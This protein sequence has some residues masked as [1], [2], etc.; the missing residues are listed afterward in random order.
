MFWSGQRN[1]GRS[2]GGGQHHVLRSTDDGSLPLQEIDSPAPSP[3]P[4]LSRELDP[5]H[6]QGENPFATPSASTTSLN[7]P[8]QPAIMYE[9]SN[10]VDGDHADQP[11][12]SAAPLEGGT[13][14]SA[15]HLVIPKPRRAGSTPLHTP[16]PPPQPLDL[17]KPRTPPPRTITPH[18]NRPPEPIPPPNVAQND[19]DSDDIPRP[20]RWWTDW[21][22]GCIE[23]GD[24]QVSTSFIILIMNREISY[25]FSLPGWTNESFRIDI[26]N[27]RFHFS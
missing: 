20:T 2:D 19:N 18:A 7:L 3:S 25:I 11:D 27:F 16:P 26:S 9:S 21:L 1:K 4:R 17:P 12:T 6:A 13:P 24:N 8:Q 22:C 23:T 5:Q 10:P 14:T 15:S